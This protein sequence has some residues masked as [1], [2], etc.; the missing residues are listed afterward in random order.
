MPMKRKRDSEGK[1]HPHAG[2][3]KKTA[4]K[5]SNYK[6]K[7]GRKEGEKVSTGGKKRNQL[8]RE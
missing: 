3:L 4:N 8:K 1:K 6:K 2:K 5:K 7:N